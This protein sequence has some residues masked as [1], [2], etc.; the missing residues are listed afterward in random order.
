[1]VMVVSQPEAK[2]TTCKRCGCVLE[3]SFKDVREGGMWD[4]TG[5]DGTYKYITCPRCDDKVIV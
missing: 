5:L 1:M 4:W 3:Y 2:R